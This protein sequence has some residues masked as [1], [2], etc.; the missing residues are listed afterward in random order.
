MAANTAAVRSIT[1]NYVHSYPR[2]IILVYIPSYS[3]AHNAFCQDRASGGNVYHTCGL[4]IKIIMP[5]SYA[6]VR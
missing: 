1:L 5:Y 4:S 3:A 6:D 2:E